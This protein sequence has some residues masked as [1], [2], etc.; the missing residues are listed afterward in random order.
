MERDVIH[1]EVRG[2]LRLRVRFRD[3]TEG[4]VEFKDEGLDDDGRFALLRDPAFFARVTCERGWLEWPME[5]DLDSA[6][7]YEAIKKKGVAIIE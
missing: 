1:A 6:A 2:P 4:E 5:V 7:L 3:G